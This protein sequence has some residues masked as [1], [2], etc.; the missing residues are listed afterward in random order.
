M[1][2]GGGTDTTTSNSTGTAT[3]SFAPWIGPLQQLVAGTGLNLTKNFLNTSPTQAVAGFNPDQQK[4]FDLSRDVAQ[5]Q[6]GTGSRTQVDPN[7]YRAGAAQLG[8]T[9]Y[10]PFLNQ[11]LGDVGKQAVDT[12]RREYDAN[13]AKSGARAANGAA[14]GGSG[15]A[16]ERAQ[17]ARGMNQ[18]SASLISNLMS[19]GFDRA[20]ALA[21]GNVNRQQQA[22]LANADNS[23]AAAGL[24]DRFKDSELSRQLA[25]IS[26]LFGA[27]NQ[28][29]G[30]AQ[31][32]LNVPFDMLQKLAALVPAQYDFKDTSTSNESK[33]QPNNSPTTFQQL[34]GGGLSLLGQ[35]NGAK[36]T[37][38]G[39]IFNKLFG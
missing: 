25:S 17:L 31:Q 13:I 39:S 24:E 22:N 36:S 9:D 2:K 4:A 28:Q 37:I 29:Q 10:M 27:G 12:M 23:L 38:G 20:N 26:S 3:R 11:Y 30:L 6:F 8:S 1:S 19:Q 15:A 5:T 7:G 35:P 14:L 21:E 34:L 33:T 16:L 18:D 32:N